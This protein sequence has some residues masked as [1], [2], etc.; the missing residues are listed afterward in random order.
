MTSLLKKMLLLTVCCLAVSQA[1]AATLVFTATPTTVTAGSSF[2]FSIYGTSILAQIGGFELLLNSSNTSTG[3]QINLTSQTLNSSDFTYLVAPP[4]FPQPL[5]TT[6]ST[7]DL[8][9]FTQDM[10]GLPG[11]V[12]YLLAS[13]TIAVSASL[14]A[15]SYTIGSTAASLFTDANGVDTDYITPTSFTFT[16]VS[17]PEPSA[18]ALLLVVVFGLCLR[19]TFRRRSPFIRY[20][21]SVI[22]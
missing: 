19:Y 8:G 2:T 6:Q 18:S 11:N 15:G 17:A 13:E 1:P 10:F 21:H 7:Q 9:A 16:V 12:Q 5:S 20:R 3:N 14:P 4:T 22:R